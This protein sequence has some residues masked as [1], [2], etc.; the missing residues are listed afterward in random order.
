M[1]LFGCQTCDTCYHASCMS[2]TLEPTEVPPFWFC[3]HCID[4]DFH[5]PSMELSE[6]TEPS[7]SIEVIRVYPSPSST[8]VTST[9][10]LSNVGPE[11]PVPQSNSIPQYVAAGGNHKI[12]GNKPLDSASLSRR[13]NLAS[14]DQIQDLAHNLKKTKAPVKQMKRSYSPPRKRSKYSAFSSE[15]DKA[16]AVITKELEKA[17]KVGKSEDSLRNRIQDLEQQLRLKDGQIM[18]TRRELELAKNENGQ[19]CQLKAELL[20]MQQQNAMLKTQ[21]DRKD[22]ELKDWREKLKSLLGNAMEIS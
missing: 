11:R 21:V 15:V 13:Q 10:V 20:D 16:L 6:T 19:S 1:E 7:P 8:E 5:I 22:S 2:P 18:L 3:P 4:R 14:I 9:E 17:A 12:G